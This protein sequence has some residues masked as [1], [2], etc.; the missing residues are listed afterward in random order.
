MVEALEKIGTKPFDASVAMRFLDAG[1]R[2]GIAK[3]LEAVLGHE[4]EAHAAL[5]AARA[6]IR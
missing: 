1:H 2:R 3:A 4:K 5:G 6:G